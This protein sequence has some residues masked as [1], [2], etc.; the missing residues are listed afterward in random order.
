MGRREFVNSGCGANSF[1]NF[2][3]VPQSPSWPQES[4]PYFK[5]KDSHTE[6]TS[7]HHWGKGTPSLTKANPNRVESLPLLFPKGFQ[8]PEG[9]PEPSASTI[10]K[11]ESVKRT[12][13]PCS[14]CFA[15]TSVPP[16]SKAMATNTY[17]LLQP[18]QE[19]DSGR[20]QASS[21]RDAYIV[22]ASVPWPLLFTGSLVLTIF[23]SLDSNLLSPL[24]SELQLSGRAAFIPRCCL[25]QQHTHGRIRQRGL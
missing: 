13:S 18:Q 16:A 14:R 6:N 23:F 8:C 17:G 15:S 21:T 10:S 5:G 24:G 3:G 12:H 22:R 20:I 9:T 7:H 4:T 25:C 1:V 11:S 19:L 2:W